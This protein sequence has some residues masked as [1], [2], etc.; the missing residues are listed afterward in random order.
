MATFWIEEDSNT[1]SNILTPSVDHKDNRVTIKSRMRKSTVQQFRSTPKNS[2]SSNTLRR[3][4]NPPPMT[5][6]QGMA[7]TAFMSSGVPLQRSSATTTR[8][9]AAIA[10]E[11]MGRTWSTV[12]EPPDIA[13]ALSEEDAFIFMSGTLPPV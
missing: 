13:T 11:K 7:A 4:S 12:S 1:Q 6:K 9:M 10:P 2:Y 3:K 8:S 5:K